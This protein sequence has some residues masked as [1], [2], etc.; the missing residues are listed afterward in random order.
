MSLWQLNTYQLLRSYPRQHGVLPRC[1]LQLR[2]ICPALLASF[3]PAFDYTA[4]PTRLLRFS[5][6]PFVMIRHSAFGLVGP[7]GLRAHADDRS[8]PPTQERPRT[9]HDAAAFWI[10]S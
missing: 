6:A 5:Q 7:G 1:F 9:P 4:E 8:R 2:Q 10:P 3:L